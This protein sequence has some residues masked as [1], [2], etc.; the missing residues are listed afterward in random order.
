MCA[1][2]F[3]APVSATSFCIWH[4]GWEKKK[5][6]PTK[7][8]S[9]SCCLQ[10][11]IHSSLASI[12]GTLVARQRCRM[13]S[14]QK[15]RMFGTLKKASPVFTRANK[16]RLHLF[17]AHDFF[18]FW[19]VQPTVSKKTF[20]VCFNAPGF[21]CGTKKWPPSSS[22]VFTTGLTSHFF[23]WTIVGKKKIYD[24]RSPQGRPRGKKPRQGVSRCWSQK[25]PIL[26]WDPSQLGIPQL[27]RS[28]AFHRRKPRRVGKTEALIL[29]GKR[30]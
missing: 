12:D 21:F 6:V 10:S 4:F 28:E 23:H 9:M 2:L 29:L 24:Q 16:K 18:S 11:S 27:W 5:Q 25:N 15:R 19:L 20:F 13:S 14:L 1:A 17:L 8:C 3:L 26:S 7:C 30:S 22:T